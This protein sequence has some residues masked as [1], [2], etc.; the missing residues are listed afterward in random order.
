VRTRE[1]RLL[2]SAITLLLTI[3][4]PECSLDLALRGDLPLAELV[5]GLVDTKLVAADTGTSEHWTLAF[6]DG[7]PLDVDRSL[8]ASGVVDGQ[9]LLLRPASE[10][11]VGVGDAVA[12]EVVRPGLPATRS[13]AGLPTGP[14]RRERLTGGRRRQIARL[15][16]AIQDVPLRRCV[17]IAVVSPKGGVGKSTVSVLLGSLLA[18][19]RV[20]RVT[21]VDSDSDYGSLGPWL[22]P[23][24]PISVNEL[25]A[26]IE[27]PGY[28]PGDALDHM[29]VGPE[30]LRICPAPR[31][32]AAM[33]SLDRD[34]YARLL[35]RLK[36][37]VGILVLDCGTGLGQPGVQAA[38]LAS[39]QLVIVSDAEPSTLTHVAQAAGLLR[40]VGPPVIAVVN[41]A[42]LKEE[43]ADRA[44]ALF[45]HASALLTISREAGDARALCAGE[46][47]WEAAPRSWQLE[48]RELAAT[49]ASGWLEFGVDARRAVS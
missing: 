38:I 36:D 2:T 25:A 16:A 6:P 35:R 17:T 43:A 27:Q 39:D 18:R 8:T 21:A 19:L 11:S 1:S 45:P 3:T 49:L 32:P 37:T 24:H 31:D 42:R 22:A 41:R 46:F 9:V 33:A 12:H 30:G 29:A 4:G 47:S 48:I 26:E 14:T 5:P 20:D 10:R 28:L 44:A 15:D 34:R 13:R 23:T 7:K 40:H